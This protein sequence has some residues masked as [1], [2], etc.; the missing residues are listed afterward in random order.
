[1]LAA[2]REQCNATR[3]RLLSMLDGLTDHQLNWKPD[4]FTWSIAQVVQHIATAEGGAAQT[5]TLG[6][7]QEPN[8]VPRDIPLKQL[9]LDRS[10]KVNA[11]DRLRPSA[12]PKT[13]AQL[14]EILDTSREKFLGALDSIKNIALLDKTSPPISHPVFGQM[15]T[16]QWITAAL[17]HEERHIQQIEELKKRLDSK[18]RQCMD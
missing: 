8:F 5:I 14:K 1:M 6:L 3:S 4:D 15:S 16:R 9:L 7:A 13:M 11:P 10:K 18:G 12:D 17:F 2:I